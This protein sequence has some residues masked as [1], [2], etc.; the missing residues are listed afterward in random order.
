MCVCVCVCIRNV[1]VT[2]TVTVIECNDNTRTNQVHNLQGNS[3]PARHT[4]HV[5][6]YQHHRG[7]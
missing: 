4:N 6:A 7:K 3:V 1:I 5:T 2:V